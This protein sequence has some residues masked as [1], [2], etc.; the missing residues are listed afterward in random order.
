MTNKNTMRMI[1]QKRATTALEFVRVVKTKD[2][3]KNEY[4]TW[5]RKFPSMIVTNGLGPTLA[6]LKSKSRSEG[7]N[8]S[9]NAEKLFYD[10]CSKYLLENTSIPWSPECK[11]K[12]D[13]L[14]AL[15]CS[16]PEI[17]R[18]A[19]MEILAFSTWLKRFAEIELT[20]TR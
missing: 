6:F 18:L 3:I 13:V 11:S 15:L 14:E 2:N 19:T 5:A 10:H 4:R 7:K 1:E 16:D 12:G 8:S 9:E 20:L 17:Y